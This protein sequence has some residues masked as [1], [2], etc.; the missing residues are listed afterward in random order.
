[1]KSATAQLPELWIYVQV[2]IGCFFILLIFNLY[3]FINPTLHICIQLQMKQFE[4]KDQ[5]LKHIFL[6]FYLKIMTDN[7][8]M[9][10]C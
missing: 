3:V 4:S 1:M 2:Q 6:I 8:N 5:I 9:S 7:R 10:M